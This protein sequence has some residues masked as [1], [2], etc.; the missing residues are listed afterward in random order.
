M[1]TAIVKTVALI[2][3]VCSP[4][5]SQ[6][7]FDRVVSGFVDTTN[8]AVGINA[9]QDTRNLQV[10]AVKFAL[11]GSD[12]DFKEMRASIENG[13][14]T[15]TVNFQG[16]VSE[17]IFIEKPLSRNTGVNLDKSYATIRSLSSGGVNTS[18]IIIPFS[19]LQIQDGALVERQGVLFA[20]KQVGKG[21]YFGLFKVEPVHGDM[22]DHGSSAEVKGHFGACIA[23]FSEADSAEAVMN[24][25]VYFNAE[26]PEGNYQPL[27]KTKYYDLDGNGT[28]DAVLTCHTEFGMGE[29]EDSIFAFYAKQNGVIDMHAIAIATYNHLGEKTTLHQIMSKGGRTFIDGKDLKDNLR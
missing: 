16:N 24:K 10:A 15:G 13:F 26:A 2:T 1:K 19:P 27:F 14:T 23:C 11:R 5:Y 3:M 8:R 29:G 25:A 9:D 21:K 6:R 12:R 28:T 20:I 7:F 17:P 4:G 18:R 22:W